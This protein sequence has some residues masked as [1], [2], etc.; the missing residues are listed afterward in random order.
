MNLIL[1]IKL[2][3]CISLN[4][5]VIVFMPRFHICPSEIYAV[6]NTMYKDS[7]IIHKDKAHIVPL[8]AVNNIVVMR[9]TAMTVRSNQ[10]LH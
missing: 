1:L 5:R 4:G 2:Q 7:S 3:Q 8:S 10:E 9:P 6:H